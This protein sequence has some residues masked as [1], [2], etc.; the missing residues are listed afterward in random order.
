[1]PSVNC[2][3]T[4]SPLQLKW[5]RATASKVK[6]LKSD[7]AK[8]RRLRPLAGLQQLLLQLIRHTL[9]VE[10]RELEQNH[11]RPLMLGPNNVVQNLGNLGCLSSRTTYTVHVLFKNSL[12]V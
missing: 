11:A 3:C 7:S 9:E 4:V 5:Q 10:L 12:I 1:M 8:T 2:K 6:N